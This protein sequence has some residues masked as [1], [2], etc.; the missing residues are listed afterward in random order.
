M[1]ERY[2]AF[3][4]SSLSTLDPDNTSHFRA[5]QKGNAGDTAM[6]DRTSSGPDA[7]C[8]MEFDTIM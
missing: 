1:E 6:Y 7:L 4:H 3:P 5:S 2:R 8:S